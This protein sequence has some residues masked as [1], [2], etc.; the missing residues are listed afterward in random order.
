MNAQTRPPE[1]LGR[2]FPGP[3]ARA[4]LRFLV[5]A[6]RR[7]EFVGDLI[8]EAETIVLPKAGARAARRWFWRQAL[9]SA[10]PLYRRRIHREVSMHRS[11][12]LVVVVL[13]VFGLLMALD[14]NVFN[15]SPATVAL[16]ILAILVPLAAGLVSG[17]LRAL[18]GAAL[19][20]A[21]LLLAARV[22]SG[23][24]IRWYAMAYVLFIILVASWLYE[25]RL[26]K[27]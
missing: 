16:V 9:G 7:E 22:V 24:E 19:C 18:A 1:S 8:E 25:R 12:W 15:A 27:P 17:N 2:E 4:V 21:L 13:P 5:P 14:P 3:L 6:Y 26:A 10:S 11:R 23:L 20:S